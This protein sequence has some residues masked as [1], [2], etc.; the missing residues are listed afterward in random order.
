MQPYDVILGMTSWKRYRAQIDYEI[1]GLLLVTQDYSSRIGSGL[2]GLILVVHSC[3][4]G[5]AA[6]DKPGPPTH[7]YLGIAHH[8]I[9]M[10]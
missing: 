5:V 2:L 6:L 4:F 8:M 7:A 9:A 1:E 3:S 10:V